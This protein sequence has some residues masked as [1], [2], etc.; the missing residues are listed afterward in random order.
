[1]SRS[2]ALLGLVILA[3]CRG[4]QPAAEEAPLVVSAAQL[5]L[6][7]ALAYEE[8]TG[9]T[10][11]I[12]IV[13]I[14]ARATG[15]LEKVLFKDG[16]DVKEGQLLY[17]IDPRTY[18]ADVKLAKGNF[19][20]NEASLAL[21]EVNFQRVV[22]LSKEKGVS[23]QEYDQNKAQRDQAAAQ[24]L[25]AKGSLDKAEL[26]LSFCK[27][28]API[29]GRISR[30]NY[31]IG[32]LVTKDLTTLTTL[33]NMDPMYAYF[34]VDEETVLRIQR[35][36]REEISETGITKATDYLRQQ[37]L[38]QATIRQAEEIIRARMNERNR[39]RLNELLERKLDADHRRQLAAIFV[40]NPRH[41]SYRNATVPVFLGTRLDKG[42]PFAGQI[43]FADNRLDPTTG[44]LRV[45]G[46]FPNKEGIL[47]PDLSVRIRMPVGQPQPALLVPDAAVVT[48]LDRKFLY[49]LDDKN[50]V[51]Q[52]PVVLG[53][54]SNGMRIIQ[55]GVQE[56]AW[57]VVSNLQ[58]VRAGMTVKR[59]EVPMPQP[60]S[61]EDMAPPPPPVVS[62]K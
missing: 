40:A 22:K 32:N 43:D 60:L 41:P 3:G 33:V 2:V 14:K 50:E 56:G 48:D 23:Q 61:P 6:G 13:D 12:P 18:E 58:R 47:T 11:A 7:K 30:S 17:Q 46:R 5:K 8:A 42:H 24:V 25:S 26:N 21:A 28:T 45:R 36:I 53:G 20:N 19:A 16:D 10:A 49:V 1:M 44:T 51:E 37:G 27:V 35:M 52:R 34:D 54:H 4:N 59:K 57:I 15:Y 39:T 9:R 55:G 29:T 38:D 62:K 31:Q